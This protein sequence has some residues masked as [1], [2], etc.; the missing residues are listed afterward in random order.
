VVGSSTEEGLVRVKAF[1][2]LNEGYE[3]SSE[4]ENEIIKFAADKLAHFKVPRWTSFVKELPRTATGKLIR[5][6][7]RLEQ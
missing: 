7:L 3:A 5:Y 1:I 4:L 2:V 6:R